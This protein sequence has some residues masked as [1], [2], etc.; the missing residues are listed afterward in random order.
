MRPWR[1]MSVSLLCACQSSSRD[2]DSCLDLYPVGMSD[3]CGVLHFDSNNLRS[4]ASRAHALSIRTLIGNR[5]WQIVC[6]P[7]A[8]GSAR[9]RIRN[10]LNSAVSIASDGSHVALYQHLLS[11]LLHFHVE[12]SY[13]QLWWRVC[14]KVYPG[15]VPR[16]VPTRRRCRPVLC[17]STQLHWSTR[18]AHCR[19]HHS[20]QLVT[21]CGTWG[22]E[23][24]RPYTPYHSATRQRT[25][26]WVVYTLATVMQKCTSVQLSPT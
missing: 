26:L 9:K 15:G 22:W 8:T 5:I 13:Q 24:R 16:V 3:K 14:V 2:H 25:P 12:Y 19:L 23:V 7:T 17:Y 18:S 6:R 11:F 10:P 1:A 4:C 21:E 20:R